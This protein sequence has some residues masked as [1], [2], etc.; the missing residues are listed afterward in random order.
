MPK[1]V[2]NEKQYRFADEYLTD[3]N[4]KQAAIRA[5]YSPKAA[6]RTAFEILRKPHIMAYLSEKKKEMASK[7]N[8]SKERTLLELG[9]L[10][11][12]DIRKLFG[13]NGGLI[14]TQDI[15]DDTAPAVSSIEIEET[16]EGIGESRVWTGY[17]KKVKMWDK[18]RALQMLGQHYGLLEADD[19]NTLRLNISIK[20]SAQDATGKH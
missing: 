17:A 14:N 1:P 6:A 9:R 19:P 2:G 20:K 7:L 4:G 16:Y 12:S 18:P 5:G 15:D 10:A 11:F 8:F 3:F 13:E